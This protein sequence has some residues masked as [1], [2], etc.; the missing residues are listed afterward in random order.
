MDQN[1]NPVLSSV[2]WMKGFPPTPFFGC[3]LR[4]GL[5]NCKKSKPQRWRRRGGLPRRQAPQT[6]QTPPKELRWQPKTSR[7]CV[8]GE[9]SA[10]CCRLF[11]D[12]GLVSVSSNFS[13]RRQSWSQRVRY[14]DEID[15]CLNSSLVKNIAEY[16]RDL[17]KIWREHPTYPIYVRTYCSITYIYPYV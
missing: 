1:Q 7:M 8:G 14:W 10:G 5:T 16:R 11:I 12:F 3:W 17:G 6:S 13:R 9:Y 2:L 4:E 15:T